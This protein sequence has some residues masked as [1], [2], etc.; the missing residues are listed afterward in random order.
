VASEKIP[1]RLVQQ[2]DQL[3]SAT[4]DHFWLDDET[5]L[6]TVTAM[7]ATGVA[8]FFQFAETLAQSGAAHGLSPEQ[9]MRLV[10]QTL[11]GAGAMAETYAQ[12]SLTHMRADVTSKGG[13][14]QAALEAFAVDD[15]FYRA[16]DAGVAACIRR[17]R[18]LA[19]D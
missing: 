2:I 17:S 15:A 14:T 3:L 19:G 13:T 1:V 7:S 9:A 6:D 10:R 12:T 8:L 11:I 4:G 5:L 18:E 16:V